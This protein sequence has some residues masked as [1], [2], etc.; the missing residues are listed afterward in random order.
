MYMYF[1]WLCSLR[2]LRKNNS[3]VAVG[4]PRAQILVSKYHRMLKR[5][6]KMADY[7]AGVEKVQGE[8][9]TPCVL[10][11]KYS[12]TNGV[13]SQGHRD[14]FEVV[15]LIKFETVVTS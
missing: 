10:E 1:S 12:N 15:S 9:G 5:T 14:W 3:P 8:P 13:K 11:V 6:R 2:G 7:R 4:I